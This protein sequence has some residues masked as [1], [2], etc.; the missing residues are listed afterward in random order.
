VDIKNRAAMI[1]LNLVGTHEVES[2]HRGAVLDIH[3]L[4]E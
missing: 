2:Y 4:F 1:G 3:A